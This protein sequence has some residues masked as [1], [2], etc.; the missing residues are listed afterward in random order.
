MLEADGPEG[1]LGWVSEL[2]AVDLILTDVVMPSMNGYELAGRLASSFPGIEVLYMSGYSDDVAVP[3]NVL[4]RRLP[5]IQKPFSV[6]S[7]ATKLRE[8]LADSAPA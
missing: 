1:A 8:V 6:S 5:F 4:E 2:D 3:E 7:L